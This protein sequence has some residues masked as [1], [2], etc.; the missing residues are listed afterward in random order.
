[1]GNTKQINITKRPSKEEYYLLLAE[2][3]QS[4]ASCLRRSYGAVIVKNDRPISIGYTGQ[5][6][7]EENCID[8][9]TCYRQEQGIPSGQRYEVCRSLHAEWNAIMNIGRDACKGATI[10][11]VGKDTN[12]K[13]YVNAVPCEI[14][15]KLI[16]E[17]GINRVVYRNSEGFTEE[18]KNQVYGG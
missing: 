14:C 1:M 9:G 7:G 3:A 8:K 4:R 16:K 17:S 12:N 13:E 15:K 18:L 6:T 5:V 10:Y 11:I 2:V